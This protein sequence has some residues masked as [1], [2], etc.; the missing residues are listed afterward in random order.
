VQVS[1]NP[2]APVAQPMTEP[3]KVGTVLVVDDETDIRELLVFFL[4]Q[5]K[6]EVLSASS[7]QEALGIYQK[8]QSRINLVISD[9]K[10]PGMS[11]AELAVALRGQHAF[12]GGFYLVTGGVNFSEGSLPKEIQGMISKPF[13]HVQFQK[14]VKEWCTKSS[15]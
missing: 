5:Y 10:M 7:A 1:N 4:E 3:A 15:K 13:S 9:M 14:I 12:T 8:H 6:L 2:A 11:G